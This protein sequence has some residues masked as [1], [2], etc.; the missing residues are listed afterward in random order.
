M[1]DKANIG[2]DS[3]SKHENKDRVFYGRKTHVRPLEKSEVLLFLEEH[4]RQGLGTPGKNLKSYGLFFKDEL[5][6]VAVFCNPRTVGMQRKYSKELFRLAFKKNTRVIGGLSKFISEFVKTEPWD[7]FTYQD[8]S[9]EATDVYE[10]AGLT[11]VSAKWPTKKVLVRDGLTRAEAENNRRDWFSLEQAVRRGPDALIGTKLG[12]VY[13]EDGSRKSNVDLFLENGYHL[14][15]IPGDRVYEW[16]NPNVW[17]YTYKVTSESNS[18]YYFGRHVIRGEAPTEQDCLNDG[19]MGSGGLKFQNWVEASGRSSLRKKVLGIYKTWEDV[20]RAEKELIG[21]K[22]SKDPLCMN[23]QPGGTGM[24]QPTVIVLQRECPQHGL[25]PHLGKSCM[26]CSAAKAFSSL[27]CSIHGETVHRGEVCMKCSVAAKWK[28]QKCSTHGE[29]WHYRNHCRRC[30]TLAN[31]SEKQCVI[32]GT[33]LH[34][35]KS[36]LKCGAKKIFKEDFCSIHGLTSHRGDSCQKCLI[37]KILHKRNCP[38][39]GLTSH[40]GDSCDRC[41]SAKVFSLRECSTHGEV[42]FRG[43]TCV[44]CSNLKL[45]TR[46][47]C[48]RHGESTFQGDTC[49]LC[50][51]EKRVSMRFCSIHGESVHTGESCFKCFTASVMKECP[52][53]G[54]TAH[55]GEHCR[56]CVA[57]KTNSLKQCELHGLTPHLGNACKKCAG[58]KS[59]RVKTCSVHGETKHKGNTCLLCQSR[60]TYS[61]RECSIHGVTSHMGDSCKKCV[62]AASYEWGYCET[63]GRVRLQRGTCKKCVI[64]RAYTTENCPVHGESKHFHGKCKKCMAAKSKRWS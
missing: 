54:L 30:E 53:H 50:S 32:H 63:H 56:K 14:E 28:I 49:A 61:Q 22:N 44:T 10:H 5:L 35:G 62:A 25:C 47:E 2:Y 37:E 11:L 58:E 7:L 18:G 64:A 27:F 33:T 26:R 38:I 55:G 3:F 57:E 48:P 43:D 15:T 41:S 34:Q 51:A 16:R 29:S 6:G 21:D 12:E 19:Y 24:V 36:C 46:R 8:T 39:H 20:V 52:V 45:I 9:G 40:R 17:F 31:R 60:K 23:M 1:V 13:R 42:L 4:H 59:I